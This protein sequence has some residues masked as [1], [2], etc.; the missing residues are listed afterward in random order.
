MEVARMRTEPPEAFGIATEIHA[1][2]VPCED[3]DFGMASAASPLLYRRG[4]DYRLTDV[5]WKAIAQIL[6]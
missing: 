3:L 4:R 2:R 6:D 5:S 1:L